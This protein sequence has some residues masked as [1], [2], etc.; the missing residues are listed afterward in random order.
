M[1]LL[2]SSQVKY[3]QQDIFNQETLAVAQP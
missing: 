1:Q 2:C 3:H